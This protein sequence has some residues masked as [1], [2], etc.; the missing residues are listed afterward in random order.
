[1]AVVSGVHVVPQ[2]LVTKARVATVV[3]GLVVSRATATKERG[4]N[5]AI[6]CRRSPAPVSEGCQ[7]VGRPIGSDCSS[8]FANPRPERQAPTFSENTMRTP[9]GSAV[10]RGTAT[11][12]PSLA[13]PGAIS[14]PPAVAER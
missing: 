14:Q 5:H 3:P 6:V 9:A 8:G 7:P 11:L 4:A 1:M 10:S 12:K 13:W 2:S